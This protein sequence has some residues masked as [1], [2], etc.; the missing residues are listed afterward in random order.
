MSAVRIGGKNRRRALSLSGPLPKIVA[1]PA[2]TVD[3]DA[4]LS[5]AG[6][7][8]D[9]SEFIQSTRLESR[10]CAET[11]KELGWTAAKA[12]AVQL[13]VWRKLAFPIAL[14]EEPRMRRPS[15]VPYIEKFNSG[16]QAWS[17]SEAN[18]AEPFIMQLERTLFFVESST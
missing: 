7:S 12:R 8:Q 16:H 11:A 15:G 10:T 14:N 1:T 3:W 9:E 2:E 17:L 18:P 6:F 5:V 4:T 13:R